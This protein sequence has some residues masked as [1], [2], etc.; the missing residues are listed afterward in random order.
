MY[1]M[2]TN[3]EFSEITDEM[4][5]TVETVFFP[6]LKAAGAM[7][8]YNIK[9]SETSATVVSIWPDQATADKAMEAV[10][11]VRSEATTSFD[12]TIVSAQS[13]PGVVKA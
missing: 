4:I 5:N 10:S 13:G 7:D 2:I 8:V 12:S 11:N 3:W 1:A 6:R 9:T